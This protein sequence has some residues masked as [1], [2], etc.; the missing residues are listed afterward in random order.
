MIINW[1]R[2]WMTRMWGSLGPLRLLKFIKM[3]Q[4]G[5][6]RKLC[7][8]Y[9]TW[10]LFLLGADEFK[11]T[12]EEE[13]GSECK[14]HRIFVDFKK[15]KWD[16]FIITPEGFSTYDCSGTC[17]VSDDNTINHLKLVNMEKKRSICCVPTKYSPFPIMF[18]DKFGNVVIKNYE[19]MIAQQCGCR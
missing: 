17:K 2:F 12:K 13:S 11:S 7:M 4:Y 19:N 10:F 14:K 9:V 15:F 5:K 3:V 16:Q 1:W 8:F 18:Y 6:V